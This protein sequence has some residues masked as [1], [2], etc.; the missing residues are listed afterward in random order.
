V[1]PDGLAETVILAG[2]MALFDE[3]AS[4]LPPVEVARIVAVILE[5]DPD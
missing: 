4:Q 2:T 1:S 5:L 3:T